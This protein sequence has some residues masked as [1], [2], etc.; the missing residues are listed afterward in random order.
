MATKG[1]GTR[2][3]PSSPLQLGV[4]D[5]EQI[6]K[7]TRKIKR[8]QS[9]PALCNPDQIDLLSP[10]SFAKEEEQDSSWLK[11]TIP[12]SNFQIFTDPQSFKK[13]KT[14]SPGKIPLF[15]F[16]VNK[17][18]FQPSTSLVN[19]SFLAT[20]PSSLTMVAQQPPLDMMDRMVAARYAP[21]VLAQPLNALPGKDYQKYL[22]RFNG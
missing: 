5:P 3:R 17:R 11:P 21:L 13:A 19:K 8:S 16:K 14:L 4:S 2:S 10:F 7:T 6:L 15:Q 18:P 22:P 1:V 9:S 20:N 12:V